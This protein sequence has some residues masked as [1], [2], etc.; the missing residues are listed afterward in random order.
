M[1]SENALVTETKD[2]DNPCNA[3]QPK[4]STELMS[5]RLHPPLRDSCSACNA[6]VSCC[7]TIMEILTIEGAT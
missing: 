3:T 5:G 7:I 1:K 4:T 6:R 2:R